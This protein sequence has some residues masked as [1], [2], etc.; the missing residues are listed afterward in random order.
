MHVAVKL[1]S[2][3]LTVIVAFPVLTA[4]TIPLEFTVATNPLLV[5]QTTWVLDALF[6]TTVA[7]S[8]LLEPL[9][10]VTAEKFKL[11]PVTGLVTLTVTDVRLFPS[12]VITEMTL[13]PFPI[14]LTKPLLLTVATVGDELVHVT[15]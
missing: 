3:V 15:I 10:I 11:T 6:G 8:V 7:K 2:A 5:D 13:I 12:C 4:L 9:F 1:P 14:A